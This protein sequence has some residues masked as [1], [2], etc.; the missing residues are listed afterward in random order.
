M[1]PGAV[2]NVSGAILLAVLVAAVAHP[3]LG[4]L[5]RKPERLAGEALRL[6]II[7]M[8]CTHCAASVR[9]ALLE[10]P[11]VT[12]AQVN[13]DDGF[14]GVQGPDAD[15]HTLV[16]AVKAIGYDAEQASNEVSEHVG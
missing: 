6:R 14:A 9:R 3:W 2:K 16:E 8:T 13:L 4:R 11:G 15:P 5:A 7:G 10:C 1:L 12:E